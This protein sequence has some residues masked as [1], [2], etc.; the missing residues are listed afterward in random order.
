MRCGDTF[1]MML[2]VLSAYLFL[3]EKRYINN[4]PFKKD[5]TQFS[6][7]EASGST[8]QAANIIEALEQESSLLLLD[9]DTCATNF[10]IRDSLMQQLVARE[11][12]PITPFIASV[13]AIFED[14]GTS[15]VMVIGSAGDYFAVADTV[16]M[17]DHYRP[18]DVTTRAKEIAAG[19][20][21]YTS[22]SPRD[23]G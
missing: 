8:S 20:L 23:R 13:R 7:T 21:L 19:C 11:K 10:M 22:P 14:L 9:E 18:I 1:G 15:V 12:E 4:L 17:M 2:S 5:T 3:P 6:T 16:L